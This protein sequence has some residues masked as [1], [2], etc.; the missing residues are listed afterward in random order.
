[1]G[2]YYG[3][4]K[5][6]NTGR[7]VV[8]NR[9]INQTNLVT[10]VDASVSSSYPGSGT[11]WTDLTGNGY[12][13]T[14]V[15]SPTFNQTGITDGYGSFAL[16]GSNQYFSSPSYP[17]GT[18]DSF[19]YEVWL[20]AANGVV[21]N[22]VGQSGGWHVSIMEIVS[23]V[24]KVGYYTG[25]FY[26]INLSTLTSGTWYCVAMTY[27]ASSLIGYVNGVQI[28]TGSA[29]KAWPGTVFNH[30]IGV[31]ESSNFGSGAYFGGSIGRVGMYSR[32]LSGS[33]LLSNFNVTKSRFGY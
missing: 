31:S 12:N 30:N 4:N 2:V 15:N 32:A 19:T 27:S 28:N 20:K 11:T 7:S 1:M 23:G 24:M 33:E 13:Y 25:T 8:S 18:F 29:T 5:N 14:A 17:A 22:E 6:S 10:N 3:I 26:S 9:L 21:M 16:N